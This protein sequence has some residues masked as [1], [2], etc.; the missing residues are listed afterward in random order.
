MSDPATSTAA[1]VALI[2]DPPGHHRR[3]DRRRRRCWPAGSTSRSTTSASCADCR[4]TPAAWTGC[5]RSCTRPCSGAR[6]SCA[7]VHGD[8]WPGN[9]LVSRRTEERAATVTG[10]VDWENATARRPARHRPG[11]LVAGRAAGRARRGRTTCVT[12]PASAAP[13]SGGA[14]DHPA[15]PAAGPGARRAADLALARDGRAWTGPPPTTSAGS[16]WPATSSRSCNW[17]GGRDH[18]PGAEQGVMTTDI[19]VPADLRSVDRP[20]PASRGGQSRWLAA[21]RWPGLAGRGA[22]GGGAAVD[23]RL[24]RR[25]P[26]RDGRLRSGVAVHRGTV[27]ALLLLVGGFLASLYRN[28]REW[29]LG[30]YLVTYIAL[31]HATPAVLYGTLRY[32]WAYKHVGIVDYILRTGTVDPT[33]GVGGIYHNWPGFFAG[34]RPAHVAGRQPGRAADRDLGAAGVQPDEPGGAAVRVP[35]ADPQQAAD[36]AGAVLLLRHHLGRAGLLLAAGDGVRAVPGLHRAADPAGHAQGAP[37]GPVPA[38][39]R[40]G[41]R[42]PPD[43]PDDAAAGRHRPGRAAAE[44]RLVPAGA[45]RRCSSRPGRSPPPAA[46]R[47]PTSWSWSSASAS[48]WPTPTRRWRRPPP[49]PPAPS[50]W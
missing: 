26:P 35:R 9:V 34:R 28:Q 15:Q 43:H 27:G 29:V 40:R 3:R 41:R 2:A 25:R 23:A 21:V 22:A 12:D 8:F 20:A 14:A 11:A 13:T 36:L 42:Q 33:I 50:R 17:L 18:R 5:G 38:G 31:I 19:T 6:S 44:L 47:C 37:A 24:R 39:R 16:G 4:A 10:I 1:A 48:R 30:F 49:S 7:W 46:T 45:R 32:S